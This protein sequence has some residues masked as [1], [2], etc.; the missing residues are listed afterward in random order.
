MTKNSI[1]SDDFATD[2]KYVVVENKE[3]GE[4]VKIISSDVS[5]EAK[6][7]GEQFA[8]E[9]EE[10]FVSD[11]EKSE[12][13]RPC[14]CRAVSDCFR[15]LLCCLFHSAFRSGESCT[16]PFGAVEGILCRGFADRGGTS[17]F[18]R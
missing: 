8:A 3:I 5:D 4:F 9:I 11:F 6:R 15:W 13:L 7:K 16:S 14:V 12:A 18:G 2:K 17:S 1:F 10:R